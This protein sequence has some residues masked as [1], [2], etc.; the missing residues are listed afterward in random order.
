MNTKSIKQF[1]FM[2]QMV[3]TKS[4]DLISSGY[5]AVKSSFVKVSRDYYL[6][7]GVL[8]VICTLASLIL[9]SSKARR[10][11]EDTVR[12]DFMIM[13]CF[14]LYFETVTTLV[15]CDYEL[16]SLWLMSTVID[17]NFCCLVISILY[18]SYE[19]N[20]KGDC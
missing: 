2:K 17:Q 4:R 15:C 11:S 9:C 3:S 16:F 20:T 5:C 10:S 1:Y 14:Y 19:S 7:H 6:I 12:N 18:D 13:L 8:K